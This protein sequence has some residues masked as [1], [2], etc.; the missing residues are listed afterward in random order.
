[1]HLPLCVAMTRSL[2][3]RWPLGLTGDRPSLCPTAPVRDDAIKPITM[4]FCVI[5]DAMRRNALALRDDVATSD[6]DVIRCLCA[7]A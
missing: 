6:G 7:M 3:A 1:M 5:V 4:T 2:R